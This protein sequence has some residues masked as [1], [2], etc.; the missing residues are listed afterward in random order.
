MSINANKKIDYQTFIDECA[1]YRE[2]FITMIMLVNDCIEAESKIT[3][4]P[5]GITTGAAKPTSSSKTMYDGY[6]WNLIA[7]KEPRALRMF[8]Q[9]KIVDECLEAIANPRYRNFVIRHSICGEAPIK[10][11]TEMKIVGGS[12]NSTGKEQIIQNLREHEISSLSS[13]KVNDFDSLD[14]YISSLG[15]A[16]HITLPDD[17]AKRR[18]FFVNCAHMYE[19]AKERELYLKNYLRGYKRQCLPNDQIDAGKLIEL[20]YL[21]AENKYVETVLTRVLKTH[22]DKAHDLIEAF[23]IKKIGLVAIEEQLGKKE[24]AVK[25]YLSDCLLDCL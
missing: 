14:L 21:R 23:Y 25:N 2:N 9:I 17:L 24:R 7:Q 12:L 6:N 11:A 4:L 20:K 10:I 8:K 1:N 15:K 5:S 18:Q 3:K 19:Y 22:G 13:H 16:A